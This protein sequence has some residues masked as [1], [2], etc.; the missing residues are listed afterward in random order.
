VNFTPYNIDT[1]VRHAPARYV[2]GRV[3]WRTVSGY[4]GYYTETTGTQRYIPVDFNRDNLCWVELRWDEQIN[5][6]E[7][8]RPAPDRLLCNIRISDVVPDSQW[9][10][11]DGE[12]EQQE[13]VDK[14]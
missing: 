12:E 7:A 3:R 2:I 14:Y 8:Y 13:A 4:P 6:W 1:R 11:I 10:P 9:G 5:K